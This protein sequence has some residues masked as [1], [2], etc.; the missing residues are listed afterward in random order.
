MKDA[1]F[2]YIPIYSESKQIGVLIYENG[3]TQENAIKILT[4]KNK[5]P[6]D[7]YRILTPEE[8][9]DFRK[10]ARDNYKVHD[11]I[12]SLWHPVV[13][14]ECNKIVQ[15]YYQSLKDCENM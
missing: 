1:I 8:E 14:D 2:E 5:I 9:V 13:I 15:E 4:K 7:M 3:M 10:W 11:R 12:D 6:K